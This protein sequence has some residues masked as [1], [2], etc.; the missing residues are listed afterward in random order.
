M[1]DE[2]DARLNR[3]SALSAGR[4]PDDDERPCGNASPEVVA[5]ARRYIADGYAIVAVQMVMGHNVKKPIG[6]I[7]NGKATGKNWVRR[8]TEE[9][10]LE[11]LTG[12][13]G[14]IA[15]GLIGGPLNG[16]ICASTS[17]PLRAT[18]GIARRPHPSDSTPT[19]VLLPRRPATRSWP[20]AAVREGCIGTMSTLRASSA[21]P[22]GSCATAAST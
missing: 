20:I 17:I 19:T 8:F 16:G 9:E 15:L 21:M 6:D 11:R 12:D 7:V 5:A 3:S 4:I 10:I 2:P 13:Y 1:T 22:R 18:S 14:G